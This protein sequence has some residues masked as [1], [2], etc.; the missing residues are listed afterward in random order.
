MNWLEFYETYRKIEVDESEVKYDALMASHYADYMVGSFD[1]ANPPD[2][3]EQK[4]ID[5]YYRQSLHYNPLNPEVLGSYAGFLTRFMNRDAEAKLVLKKAIDIIN[6]PDYI[7]PY[8]D[9]LFDLLFFKFVLYSK[10]LA[11][12]PNT[13][14]EAQEY[15]YKALGLDPGKNT[16]IYSMYF[17]HEELSEDQD[18]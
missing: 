18:N 9:T 14:K 15:K 6:S 17:S 16:D 8:Y 12:N 2:S 13:Q 11:K 3:K 10:L 7:D 4:T 1:E 5:Q